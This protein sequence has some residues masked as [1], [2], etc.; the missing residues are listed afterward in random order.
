MITGRGEG[1]FDPWRDITEVL[2][3][4]VE[5]NRLIAEKA[6]T[7]LE[8][9][10]STN[11]ELV[12]TVTGAVQSL[13]G[14]VEAMGA[15]TEAIKTQTETISLLKADVVDLKRAR[16][17]EIEATTVRKGDVVWKTAAWILAAVGGLVLATVLG[18]SLK[19]CNGPMPVVMESA[20]LEASE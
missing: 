3:Q 19:G 6:V 5:Q 20:P 10:N 4:V 17:R 15:Q 12:Q 7:A 11:A 9:S 1:P 2:K 14:A 16:E 13:S 8:S 18:A